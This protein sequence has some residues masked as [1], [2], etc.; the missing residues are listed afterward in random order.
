MGRSGTVLN[1]PRN[2]CRILEKTLT[3]C[4]KSSQI[5]KSIGRPSQD[6]AT[7]CSGSAFDAEDGVQETMIRACRSRDQFD[8]R[9]SVKTWLYRIAT[10]VCLDELKTRSRRAR[11]IE[12]ARL[13]S[14]APPM[15]AFTQ[16]ASAY[17]RRQINR[18][19]SGIVSNTLASFSVWENAAA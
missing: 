4:L 14:G 7:G 1:V 3:L 11:P 19:I 16:R 9:A 12:E 13:L 8:G 15:E 6:T 10:N 5:S 18:R 17:S 2:F